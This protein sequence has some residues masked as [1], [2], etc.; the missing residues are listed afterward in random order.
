MDDAERMNGLWW[1]GLRSLSLGRLTSGTSG[2]FLFLSLCSSLFVLFAS[3]SLNVRYS[4]GRSGRRDAWWRAVM[5]TQRLGVDSIACDG[6]VARPALVS[7]S[8]LT[9]SAALLVAC[10]MSFM[11]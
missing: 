3:F 9:V 1:Y 2:S 11:G 8:V 6:A 4:I 10:F 5:T 7:Q